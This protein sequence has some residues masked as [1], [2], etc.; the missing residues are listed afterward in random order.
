[1]DLVIRKMKSD[2]PIYPK[3]ESM[4]EK[5]KFSSFPEDYD[6]DN[7]GYRAVLRI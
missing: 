1:M 4:L 7:E 2:N 3:L 5:V 6:F